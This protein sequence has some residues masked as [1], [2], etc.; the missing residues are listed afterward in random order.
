MVAQGR[1]FKGVDR[2]FGWAR[3]RISVSSEVMRVAV[4]RMEG[5]IG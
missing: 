2:S 3:V 4:E 1:H 5:V